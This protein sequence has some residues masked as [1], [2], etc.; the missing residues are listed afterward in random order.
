VC[1]LASH[2]V[3]PCQAV[4][5]EDDADLAAADHAVRHGVVG[6]VIIFVIRSEIVDELQAAQTTANVPGDLDQD[7]GRLNPQENGPAPL[8]MCRTPGF[9]ASGSRLGNIG[10]HWQSGRHQQ[11][12][13]P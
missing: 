12:G 1:D 2:V 9:R 13:A 5:D 8:R 4:A 11:E 7:V 3:L 10:R 6:V